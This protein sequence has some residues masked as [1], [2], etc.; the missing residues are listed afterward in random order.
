MV[1]LGFYI[2]F[3]VDIFVLSALFF[4]CR[5]FCNLS[6]FCE[7]FEYFFSSSIFLQWIVSS[8]VA[9]ALSHRRCIAPPL[10]DVIQVKAL[11]RIQSMLAVTASQGVELVLELFKMVIRRDGETARRRDETAR[12]DDETR[13]R[14]GETAVSPGSRNCTVN[15]QFLAQSHKKG[16]RFWDTTRQRDGETKRRRDDETE[17]FKRNM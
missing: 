6:I 1:R 13:Q 14:D 8:K 9:L 5:H 17:L 12:R 4:S 15:S 11:H 7:I 10:V 16:D 2:I 3:L